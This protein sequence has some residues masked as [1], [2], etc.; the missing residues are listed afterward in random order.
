MDHEAI[1]AQKKAWYEAN[2]QRIIAKQASRYH[3]DPDHRA[4]V[5]SDSK[6]WYQAHRDEVLSRRKAN[7]EADGSPSVSPG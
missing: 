5:I 4:K 7:R 1:R 2:K 3:S 6:A